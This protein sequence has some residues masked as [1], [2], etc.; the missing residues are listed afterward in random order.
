MK[1]RR[2]TNLGVT[3]SPQRSGCSPRPKPPFARVGRARTSVSVPVRVPY[4]IFAPEAL[5][6][7]WYADPRRRLD[8]ESAAGGWVRWSR[9]VVP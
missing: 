1:N 4:S 2:I 8:G 5:R 3:I 7:W 9:G 6:T